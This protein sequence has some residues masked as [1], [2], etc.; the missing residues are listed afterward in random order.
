[1]L[2]VWNTLSTPLFIR[3]KLIVLTTTMYSAC[4]DTIVADNKLIRFVVF[5]CLLLPDNIVII[6][7][8]L[9]TI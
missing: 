9:R 6:S 8:N 5:D 3:V 1:M 2:I 7:I 4:K